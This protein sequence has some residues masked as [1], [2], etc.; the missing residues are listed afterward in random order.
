[1]SMISLISLCKRNLEGNR[2]IKFF[3]VQDWEY[4][5]LAARKFSRISHDHDPNYN[6]HTLYCTMRILSM[7]VRRKNI[8]FGVS[9]EFAQ[10]LYT[11]CI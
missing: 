6:S 1:M 4:R 5:Y 8:K 3:L 2:D 9:K 7:H 11:V 10:P